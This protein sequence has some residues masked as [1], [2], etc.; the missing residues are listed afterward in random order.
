MDHKRKKRHKKLKKFLLVCALLGTLGTVQTHASGILVSNPFGNTDLNGISPF[1]HWKTLETE[2]FRISFPEEFSVVAQ[3]VANLY[4]EAH[5]NYVPLFRWNTLQKTLVVLLD[6]RDT[7]NGL[8]SP[9]GRYGMVLWLTPPDSADSITFYDE[10]LRVLVFHEYAHFMNMDTTNGLYRFARSFLLDLPLPNALWAPWMLEGL[11]VYL[12]TQFT[13]AG[14][15]RSSDYDMLLRSAVAEN[16]LNTRSFMTLDLVNGNNP[17]FPVG[18]TRYQFGYQLMNQVSKQSRL[19]GKSFGKD[20]LGL[21][22]FQSA[23]DLPFFIN[24]TLFKVVKKDWYAIWDE[25]VDQTRKRTEKDIKKIK[26]QPLTPVRVLTEQTRAKSNQVGGIAAS[27]DGRWLAYTQASADQRSGLYLR[28]LRG[29]LVRRLS[30]KLYGMGMS[31]TPDSKT[32]IYSEYNDLDQFSGVSDLKAYDLIH[33]RDYMLSERLRAKDPD[34]SPDGKWVTFTKT[35]ISRVGLARAPL[36]PDRSGE[37]RLGPVEVLSMPKLYERVATPKFSRDGHR[38]YYTLHPNEKFQEDLMEFDLDTR[39]ERTLLAD[40]K[41]NRFPAVDSNGQLHFV[42][43]ATGVDNLYR[44]LGHGQAP[45]LMTNVVSGV[46]LPAFSASEPFNQKVYLSYFSSSGWDLAEASLELNPAQKQLKTDL[47]KIAPPPAPALS[48]DSLHKTPNRTYPIQD[49]SVFPSLWPRGIIPV[50]A[51]DSR[52]IDIGAQTLGFDALNLHRYVLGASY[53]TQIQSANAFGLYSNRTLGS[54]FSISGSY[55]STI[56]DSNQ[57]TTDFTQVL[58]AA[59]SW[60][61]P[62]VRT[63]SVWTP[64]LSVTSQRAY[65]YRRVD[66]SPVQFLGET[67]LISSADFNLSFSNQETSNLAV[68]SEGGRSAHLGVRSYFLPET[69]VWKAF[70]QEKEFLRLGQHTILSP[71]IAGEWVSEM[72]QSYP[73]SGALLRGRGSSGLTNTVLGDSLD[74]LGIRGYPN[75]LLGGG[76]VIRPSLDFRMPIS[77]I[78]G[79]LGTYRFFFNNLYTLAFAET[80]IWRSS[81]GQITYLPAVGAGIRL[82]SEIFYIPVTWGVEYHYG[83][84]AEAGGRQDLFLNIQVTGFS[85]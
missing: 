3:R 61:Y 55:L 77:R 24:D 69:V 41:F 23:S 84:N 49:Y 80:S 15:G 27:P 65:V 64:S 62:I 11:A 82:S 56:T 74:W 12:E 5:D 14:R 4:E 47:A 78:F 81:Q 42:S 33:D 22:S 39:T 46:R 57:T 40:G 25:W 10:W 9:V 7:A 76:G 29:Q 43:N 68:F 30:D 83:L 48:E 38:I 1:H 36:N 18:D 21:L 53:T 51:V 35:A 34:V 8:T 59:I 13:Q 26:S 58:S 44:Y 79:G 70:F 31:F 37:F 60:A 75:R 66:G 54:D 85:F 32:L 20:A 71:S 50:G 17:Y 67:P 63:Y 73:M 45:R 16:V 2:H 72:G 6:N 28:D 19:N 52:G